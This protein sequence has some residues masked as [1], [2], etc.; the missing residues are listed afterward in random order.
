MERKVGKRKQALLDKAKLQSEKRRLRAQ[1]PDSDK[2]CPVYQNSNDDEFL[3]GP[4]SVCG[5]AREEHQT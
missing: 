4:C 5:F 1:V 3:N 2:P